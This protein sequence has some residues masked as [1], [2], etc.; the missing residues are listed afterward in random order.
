M[1]R[2][3]TMTMTMMTTNIVYVPAPTDV[4]KP[5][6]MTKMKACASFVITP[7]PPPEVVVIFSV[8]S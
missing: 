2:M 3:T 7:S 6:A 4:H 5:A 1:M 8:S